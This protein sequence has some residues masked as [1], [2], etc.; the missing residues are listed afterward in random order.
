MSP[1][2]NARGLGLGETPLRRWGG[3]RGSVIV[4]V[5]HRERW[6]GQSQVKAKVN[7]VVLCHRGLNT[8]CA[9]A[10]FLLCKLLMMAADSL[11]THCEPIAATTCC[12]G[13]TRAA[14]SPDTAEP[15]QGQRYRGCGRLLARRVAFLAKAYQYETLAKSVAQ[16]DKGAT[17]LRRPV[18]R[19]RLRTPRRR[20][21][22]GAHRL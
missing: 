8:L 1:N 12:S 18:S 11:V 2:L 19:W 7:T 14:G 17:G 15:C 3:Y 6:Q 20:T 13:R 5:G 22:L 4:S 9:T 10:W 21:L 16:T